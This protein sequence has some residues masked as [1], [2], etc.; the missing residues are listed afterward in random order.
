MKYDNNKEQSHIQSTEGPN[1]FQL[2]SSSF[3]VHCFTWEKIIHHFL[4]ENE[5]SMIFTYVLVFAQQLYSIL[6]KHII[7]QQEW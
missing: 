2:N 7:I 1:L 3:S 4:Y 6:I 5:K